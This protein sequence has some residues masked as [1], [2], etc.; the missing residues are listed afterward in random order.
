M[1]QLDVELHHLRSFI[2]VVEQGSL[3]AAALS[4]HV[5]QPPLTRQMQ[6]LEEAVG[7]ELLV[8]SAHGVTVSNAGQ[9]FY[10]EARNILALTLRATRHAKFIGQGHIGRL[11]LGVFGSPIFDMIP[12]LI[13]TFNL[14]NPSVEVAL[15]T[16]NRSEQLKALRERRIDLGFNRFVSNEPGLCWETIESQPL[17]AAIFRSHKL[18]ARSRVTLKQLVDERLILYPRAPRPGFADHVLGLFA[19]H[20]LM[21]Q[22]AI[23]VDDMP[24]AIATVASG[25]GIA[26]VPSSASKLQLQNVVYR[27]FTKTNQGTV[28]SCI[29]YRV[30]DRSPL[31]RKFVETARQ[32]YQSADP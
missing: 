3:H 7:T 30:D 29:I 23:N 12:R 5:S 22:S 11:D 14:H 20:G 24:T 19:R 32:Y 1:K 16:L 4:L 18:A 26:I 8:R 9:K 15:H 10:I 31:L 27:P 6:Q 17:D 25:R 28:E 21:P 13:G 2:A